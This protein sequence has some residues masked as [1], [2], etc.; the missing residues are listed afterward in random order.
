VVLVQF[1]SETNSSTHHRTVRRRKENRQMYEVHLALITA[2]VALIIAVRRQPRLPDWGLGA[3]LE[4]H[5]IK[6]RQ[7]LASELRIGASVNGGLELYVDQTDG[8]T[9]ILFPYDVSPGE[10]RGEAGR[11]SLRCGGVWA[12][13]ELNSF[14]SPQTL[15]P[16]SFSR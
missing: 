12:G 13:F 6:A 15:G 1:A 8:K 14:C 16:I 10:S 5:A 7:V 11:V 9:N 2:V 3:V 4:C